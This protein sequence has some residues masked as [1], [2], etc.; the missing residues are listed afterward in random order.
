MKEPHKNLPKNNLTKDQHRRAGE[1]ASNLMRKPQIRQKE[2]S[3]N[4]QKQAYCL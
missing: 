2:N 4:N 1:L 3:K